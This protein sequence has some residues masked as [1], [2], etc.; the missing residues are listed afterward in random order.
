MKNAENTTEIGRCLKGFSSM[1]SMAL[2]LFSSILTPATLAS[3]QTTC[4]LATDI[5]VVT[6]LPANYGAKGLTVIS[7][8]NGSCVAMPVDLPLRPVSSRQALTQSRTAWKPK[9]ADVMESLASRLGMAN[10]RPI[11]V[12]SHRPSSSERD[13]AVVRF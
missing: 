12:S 10:S 3:G 9:L 7:N 13:N 6:P 2:F 8:S 11:E 5:Q 1:R 4:L